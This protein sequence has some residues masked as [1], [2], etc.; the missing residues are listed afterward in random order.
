MPP[1]FTINTVNSKTER[2]CL[3]E[4]IKEC[5]W[6][7]SKSTTEG[8][9]IWF[10]NPLRDIDLKV[11]N[12]KTCYFNRYPRSNV[13][14]RKRQFSILMRKYQKYFPYEFDFIPNTIVLPDEYKAFKKHMEQ[15]PVKAMLAKPSRGKGGEG[16]FFVKSYKDIRKET[17][18]TYEYI[19][20]D[21]LEKPLLV[22][23]KKFDFLMYL[24]VTGTDSMTAYLAFEGMTRFCTEE[25]IQPKSVNNPDGERDDL[26][27][28]LTNYTLNKLNHK[29]DLKENFKDMDT[30]HKRLLSNVM[31]TLRDMGVDIEDLRDE[32]KDMAT[33]IVIAMQPFLVNS[34]HVE[35]GVGNEVNQSCFHIFGVDVMIDENHK[36]WLLEIN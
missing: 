16:I 35:M 15:K 18:K 1:V 30:G 19:V 21:Y 34:Y 5:G 33:K 25:Y 23:D 27:A 3:K 6:K 10:V 20:Q 8:S 11:L 4:V 24:L 7:E 17:M 22:D 14:C 32:L 12:Y 13:I 31:F 2:H 28:H 9:M 36:P 26:M 29:F